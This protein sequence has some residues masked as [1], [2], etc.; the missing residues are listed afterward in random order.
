MIFDLTKMS[1]TIYSVISSQSVSLQPIELIPPGEPMHTHSHS[2][3][4][5]PPRPYAIQPPAHPSLTCRHF[6]L[7]PLSRYYSSSPPHTHNPILSH[8]TPIPSPHAP[9]G[10]VKSPLVAQLPLL[11]THLSLHTMLTMQQ[12][13]AVPKCTPRRSP[14]PPSSPPITSHPSPTRTTS[15]HPRYSSCFP[16][17]P[18]MP[19]RTGHNSFRLSLLSPSIHHHHAEENAHPRGKLT[20]YHPPLSQ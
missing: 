14:I 4:Q 7:Q 2:L 9:P 18:S 17:S 15:E 19:D 1:Q 13:L 3:H 11:L 6:V 16:V 12:Y 10:P 5:Q 20:S 8:H